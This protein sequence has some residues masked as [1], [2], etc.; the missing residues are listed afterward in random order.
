MNS[1]HLVSFRVYRLWTQFYGCKY[2]SSLFVEW[3]SVFKGSWICNGSMVAPPE[4]M[5]DHVKGRGKTDPTCTL[6]RTRYFTFTFVGYR[7]GLENLVVMDLEVRRDR[8]DTGTMFTYNP[9]S[10]IFQFRQTYS[11]TPGP[12]LNDTDKSSWIPK[13]T[14]SL[15]FKTSQVGD[16]KSQQTT[17]SGWTGLDWRWGSK[18]KV[19][20]KELRTDHV[21]P[22]RE[23]GSSFGPLSSCDFDSTPF[24]II[25]NPK[26][27]LSQNS[28]KR[29]DSLWVQSQCHG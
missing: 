29:L 3:S 27:H 13:R 22:S 16:S 26:L 15:F 21:N 1:S 25:K 18:S 11:P 23:I 8:E 2:L 6:V 5:K 20:F 7:N 4:E 10:T 19:K 17:V 9:T 14:S 12:P 24:G 28:K